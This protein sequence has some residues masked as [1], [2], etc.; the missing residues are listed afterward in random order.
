MRIRILPDNTAYM[1]RFG[2]KL[3]YHNIGIGKA[4]I[5]L[6]DKVL[7]ARGV[8]R[9]CLHTAS[10]YGDLV[11]FYYGRGFHIDS[12]TR[13]RGYIRALMVKEYNR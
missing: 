8:A 13:D 10:K 9:V 12:T 7:I 1:S 2:V 4:L 5:N 6:V 3:Q 11:R